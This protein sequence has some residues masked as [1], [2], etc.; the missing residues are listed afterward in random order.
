MDD[1]KKATAALLL[2]IGFLAWIV[3]SVLWQGYIVSVLWRWF[4]VPTFAVRGLSIIQGCGLT[5]TVRVVSGF[6]PRKDDGAFGLRSLLKHFGF[7][8]LTLLSGYLL[9]R[10]M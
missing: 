10:A 8:V 2:A 4:L 9:Q 6:E 7:G 3:V 1:D 5:L